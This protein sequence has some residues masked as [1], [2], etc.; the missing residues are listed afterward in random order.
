L[1]YADL[2]TTDGHRYEKYHIRIIIR[3]YEDICTYVMKSICTST[4]ILF[5][6]LH[7]VITQK[8]TTLM[9]IYTL[10]VHVC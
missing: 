9:C 8:T 4:G 2:N 5:S 7:S 3:V 10:L 6:L 1:N